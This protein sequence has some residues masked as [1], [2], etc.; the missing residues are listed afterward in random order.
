MLPISFTI[1]LHIEWKKPPALS[2][3]ILL[4]YF[5]LLFLGFVLSKIVNNTS[6]F[7]PSL[8][9]S[10]LSLYCNHI[11]SS[12]HFFFQVKNP[13][14]FNISSYASLFILHFYFF[15]FSFGLGRSE[16]C[17]AFK[18]MWIMQLWNTTVMFYA[19]VLLFFLFSKM[20]QFWLLPFS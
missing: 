6:S 5:F 13:S 3:R 9:Y 19:F 12:S 11:F 8:H 2:S 1:H 18:I 10:C 14:W 17:S 4:R 16:R 15:L 20:P 7:S